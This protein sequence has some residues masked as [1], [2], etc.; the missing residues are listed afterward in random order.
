[1]NYIT[2][3]Q[4]KKLV[5]LGLNPDTADMCYIQTPIDEYRPVAY[6]LEYCN[7]LKQQRGS[8]MNLIPA[9]SLTALLNI[10]DSN[11]LIYDISNDKNREFEILVYEVNYISQEVKFHHTEHSIVDMIT[12]LLEHDYI[13][14]NKNE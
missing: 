3:E 4:S 14:P 9:W 5:E 11:G 10:I 13:K 7:Q 6:S 8:D 1:M 12:W 2:I